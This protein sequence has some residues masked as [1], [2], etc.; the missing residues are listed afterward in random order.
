[1]RGHVWCNPLSFLEAVALFDS[2]TTE[3]TVRRHSHKA[4][5]EFDMTARGLNKNLNTSLS[6]QNDHS[7]VNPT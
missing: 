1:M 2:S 3:G 6:V 7:Q 5:L 4:L